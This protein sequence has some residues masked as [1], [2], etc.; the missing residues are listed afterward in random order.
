M[1]VNDISTIIWE[2]VGAIVALAIFYK[3]WFGE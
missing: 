2:I 1:T 3:I